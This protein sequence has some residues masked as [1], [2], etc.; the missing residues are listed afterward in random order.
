MK[1]LLSSLALLALANAASAQLVVTGSSPTTFSGYDGQ[2]ATVTGVLSTGVHG[3]LESL[4]GGT[5]TFTYL[6]NESGNTN[7]FTFSA[8]PQTL[9]EASALGSSISGAIGG[10]SLGFGFTDTNTASTFGNGSAAIVYVANVNT[11]S[12]GNF[13]Y[14]IGFNDNGSND[15][16]FDDF[17]VG[18]NVTTPVPEPETYALMLAGLSAMGF[19]ARRRRPQA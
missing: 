7:L 13:Q 6:G 1:R 3:T 14:V 5:A 2:P 8:G 4:L 19:M 12:Y 10:G 17:V 16:D 11:A 18:V 9:T 15:G